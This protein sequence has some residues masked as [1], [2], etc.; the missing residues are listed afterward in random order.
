MRSCFHLYFLYFSS[1][2]P[3]ERQS[4]RQPNLSC[5]RKCQG[6]GTGVPGIHVNLAGGAVN[7]TVSTNSQGLY[8]FTNIAA[9]SYT[10]TPSGN[11]CTFDP[12]EIPVTIPADSTG[13]NFTV[14]FG[15]SGTVTISGAGQSGVTVTLSGA[16]GQ[17]TTTDI[18]GNYSFSPLS[19]GAYTVTPD[20]ARVH[21]QPSKAFRTH[22]DAPDRLPLT[23][24][25]RRSPTPSAAPPPP[26]ILSPMLRLILW[27]QRED[28]SRQQQPQAPAVT[29][30]SIQRS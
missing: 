25:Q 1:S 26:E 15:I 30:A 9:G 14:T 27:I 10:I 18:G 23:L 4:S 16:A 12:P 22:Q 20:Q 29:S 28:P 21:I 19:Q 3:A 13:N 7:K 24:W 11:G 8:N 17:T 6:R 2:V 5:I